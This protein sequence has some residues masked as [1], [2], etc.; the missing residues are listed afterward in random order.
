MGRGGSIRSFDL[1]RQCPCAGP[2][3]HGTVDPAR[4]RR[5][6]AGNV[7]RFAAIGERFAGGWVAEDDGCEPGHQF[8][9]AYLLHEADSLLQPSAPQS[10]PDA[11]R[12]IEFGRHYGIDRSRN[13]AIFSVGRAG[14]PQDRRARLWAQT[15][16][17]R[18]ALVT[19]SRR[20]SRMGRAHVR[21]SGR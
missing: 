19:A 18:I 6:T 10:W 4:W 13:V 3:G 9:W 1:R 15:E 2:A 11:R 21:R 5:T 12:L 7:G 8:E 17:L 14:V 16:R 20:A